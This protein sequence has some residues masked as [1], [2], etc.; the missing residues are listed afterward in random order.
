MTGKPDSLRL[1][2]LDGLRGLAA[3]YV[4]FFHEVLNANE[5]PGEFSPVMMRV[6]GFFYRGHYAVVFF[7]VLSGFSLMLPI[8]RSGTGRVVGG[9]KDFA[10]RRARRIL[11]TYYA[12]LA[13]SLGIIAM[14]FVA[15]PFVHF[16]RTPIEHVFEPGTI[17]SHLFLVHNLVLDWAYKINSPMWS[18][19]TEWQIYFVFALLLL[20]L[21]RVT[22][23]L[24]TVAVAWTLGC[25]PHFLLPASSNLS[26]ACPW[27]LGSFAMGMVGAVIG[28]SPSHRASVWTKIPPL[29]PLILSIGVVAYA[30]TIHEA[31][32]YLA[33]DAAVS[34]CALAFI[35]LGVQTRERPGWFLK[36]LG[37]RPLV[38]LGGFSY[39][40]YLVQHPFLTMA[41]AL[42][43]RMHITR[44]ANLLI[45]LVVMTPLTLA[46][47]WLFAEFFEKPFTSGSVLIAAWR[48]RRSAAAQPAVSLAD[49]EPRADS[50]AR[51]SAAVASE[52]SG[53]EG[54]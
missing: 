12:A 30:E 33:L 14:Y 23:N 8:A 16:G 42:L 29:V 34:L 46:V 26:W 5:A 27:F 3:L 4:V 2:F 45:E 25:L 15:E 37:S 9:L 36:I 17:L 28:F 20:P 41:K 6:R 44:N 24:F 18:V 1:R 49:G 51:R 7:I 31:W 47:C 35:N 52:V 38:A 53:V 22:G 32:Y 19:A 48:K 50:S 11:P 13:L 21:W 40:L 10:R 39:S 43:N 54:P